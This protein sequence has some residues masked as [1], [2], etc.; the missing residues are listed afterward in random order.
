MKSYIIY[1]V[2]QIRVIQSNSMTWVW[3]VAH[4]GDIRNAYRILVS[5]PEG[6]RPLG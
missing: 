1:T 4:M 6:K 2:H 5:E 3:H